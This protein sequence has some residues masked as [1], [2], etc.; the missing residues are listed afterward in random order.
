MWGGS[1]SQAYKVEPCG[2]ADFCWS[3]VLCVGTGELLGQALSN[4]HTTVMGG[5]QA[6]VQGLTVGTK[7]LTTRKAR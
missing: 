7:V 4:L 2:T 5:I 1:K 3:A 6:A